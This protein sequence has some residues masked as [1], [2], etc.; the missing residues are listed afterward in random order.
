MED[1]PRTR[2]GLE[3]SRDC[4]LDVKTLRASL[5]LVSL[6]ACVAR[7]GFRY[8]YIKT[9]SKKR[10]AVVLSAVIAAHRRLLPVNEAASIVMKARLGVDGFSEHYSWEESRNEGAPAKVARIAE[11][12][13]SCMESA[14]APVFCA[15]DMLE[16][17]IS[18]LSARIRREPGP[19]VLDRF[20]RD[21]AALLADKLRM[22][23]EL[24]DLRVAYQRVCEARARDTGRL[25]D[26]S[27]LLQSY[28]SVWG[29]V[30]PR[31]LKERLVPGVD[32]V[33]A[34]RGAVMPQNRTDALKLQMAEDRAAEAEAALQAM[35]VELAKAQATV[36]RWQDQAR[37]HRGMIEEEKQ[38]V[39]DAHSQLRRQ[40]A[41]H[42]EWSR[43]IDTW[44]NRATGLEDERRTMAATIR[45]DTEVL[46]RQRLEIESLR[47]GVEAV[48]RREYEAGLEAM[49][50]EYEARVARMEQAAQS[51][52][53]DIKGK[54]DAE[55]V[56]RIK[57]Q[58]EVE[59]LRRRV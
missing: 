11:P 22:S 21:N 35:R 26:A 49:R 24:D 16:A 9:A 28:R 39:E 17:Q 52:L 7:T 32:V 44:K 34:L 53:R 38:R 45:K 25:V 48:V 50:V 29:D 4:H 57:L 13:S 10:G 51:K 36:C 31:I 23:R 58:R 40:E 15:V 8:A 1:S 46:H 2:F 14:L 6:E 37:L 30:D 18:V 55:L 42:L 27:N 56:A 59:T 19:P 20:V 43:E 47:A 54:R 5:G 3:V 33:A 41:M 12:V